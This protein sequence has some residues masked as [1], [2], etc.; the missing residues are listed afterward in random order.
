VDEYV[1]PEKTVSPELMVDLVKL[2]QELDYDLKAFQHVLLLTKTFQFSANSE[3][4]EAGMPQAFNGRQV[5]RM[6][7]EQVW[8]SLVT[9]VKGDPDKLP[10]RRYSD[11][12][13][14][15]NK[16]VLV[17]AKSMSQL[18][19]EILAI[20]SPKEY[21]ADVGN[22]LKEMKTGGKKKASMS[23]TGA[24]RP[25]PAT[26]LARASELA[27]PAP[28]GHFLREFG[29][30][31]RDL[32]DSA[33]NEANMAQVLSIMNG[34]VESMVVSNE[35]SALYKA[36]EQ[37]TTDRD[38]VRYIFYSVLSRPPAEDEMQMLMR[39]VIDGSKSSYRNLASALL[40][41]HEFIFIY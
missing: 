29:Q 18:N 16:P 38:K 3:A 9:L 12:I 5:V 11:T 8:D 21:R 37:G 10:K 14:Y 1:A 23:M 34:Y 15:R 4:F 2:L 7:A 35:N 26:G 25:G 40:A 19:R 33:S 20:K 32:I 31:D 28:V 6:Q 39:D 30:S 41:S 36:L 22:L 13:Y 17:G 24:V 27:S